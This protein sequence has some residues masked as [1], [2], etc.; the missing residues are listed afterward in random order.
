MT[1]LKITKA[2]QALNT[3]VENLLDYTDEA[4]EQLK[5]LAKQNVINIS[6]WDTFAIIDICYTANHN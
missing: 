2:E 1:T 5:P 6:K 4:V 3:I